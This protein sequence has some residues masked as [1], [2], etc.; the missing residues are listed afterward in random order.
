MNFRRN[1]NLS[2]FAG[3]TS[4]PVLIHR[5][6]VTFFKLKIQSQNLCEFNFVPSSFPLEKGN[7]TF[8]AMKKFTHIKQTTKK[9]KNELI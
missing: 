1:L 8:P 4:F 5:K 6:N 3:P 9:N 7:V 2:V